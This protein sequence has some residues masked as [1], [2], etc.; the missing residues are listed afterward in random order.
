MLVGAQ[1]SGRVF[2]GVVSGNVDRA[3]GQ[4]Q[5]FWIIPAVFAALIL[6]AFVWLFDNCRRRTCQPRPIL[7]RL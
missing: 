1:V 4:W 5:T 2:N 6:G 7:R 3:L